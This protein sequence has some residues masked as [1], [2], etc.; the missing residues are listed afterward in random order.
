MKKSN[1]HLQEEF[2]NL[3]KEGLSI[4]DIAKKYNVSKNSVS[5]LVQ[6]KMELRPKT[7]IYEHKKEIVD[8]FL[9]GYNP[10]QISK[11]LNLSYSGIKNILTKEGLLNPSRE[12]EHLANTFIKEYKEGISANEIANKHNVSVQTVINYL[13][14]DKIQIR[15][16]KMSGRKKEIDDNYFNELNEEK[17]YILGKVFAI[18]SIHKVHSSKFLE[19]AIKEDKKDI[20]VDTAKYFL[21]EED[22]IFCEDKKANVLKLR[23]NSEQIYNILKEYGIG[24]SI[25]IDNK[26]K[27]MFFKGYLETNLSINNRNIKIHSKGVYKKDIINYLVNDLNIPEDKIQ[28]KY[29]IIIE[30]KLTIDILIK[31]Y[32]EIIEK[33]KKVYSKKWR[34][35]IVEYNYIKYFE[36]F[37]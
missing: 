17:A 35:F 28:K 14:T 2:I 16:Y 15:D 4:R 13:R 7:K 31:Y 25:S 10:N 24:K 21:K 5:S 27:Y 22:M 32:P 30:E 1:R 19:L 33:I 34:N 29:S 9:K 11:L 37:N 8:L 18:G 36:N 6:E 12:F 26:Y 3:Y 20:I 23:I